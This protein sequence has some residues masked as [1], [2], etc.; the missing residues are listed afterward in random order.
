MGCA[1]SLTTVW[2][3]GWWRRRPRWGTSAAKYREEGSLGTPPLTTQA[4]GVNDGEDGMGKEE[5][6]GDGPV[7]TDLVDADNG[8]NH[9]N[10]F[11]MF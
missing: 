7:V 9:L 5:E 1:H 4:E 6:D 3:W 11:V 10:F 8:S 2:P